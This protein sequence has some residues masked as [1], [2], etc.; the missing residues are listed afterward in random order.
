MAPGGQQAPDGRGTTG[1][2]GAV[3]P[4][5]HRGARCVAKDGG[6]PP[7]AVRRL[8][9]DEGAR[10]PSHDRAHRPD[11]TEPAT[12]P[13]DTFIGRMVPPGMP[14]GCKRIRYAGVQAT[15]TWA[16]VTLVR[17]AALAKGEEVSK[18]A[19]HSIARLTSRQR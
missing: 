4:Q 13:G 11:R 2:K 19:V 3:P 17:P 10:G 14:K 18:G 15:K 7:S 1:H 5:A 8:A 12:V 16:K 6:S 9:R